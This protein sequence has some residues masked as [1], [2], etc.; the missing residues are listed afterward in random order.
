MPDGRIL[1]RDFAMTPRQ[2]LYMESRQS[3]ARHLAEGFTIIEQAWPAV[4]GMRNKSSG[5]D[6]ASKDQLDG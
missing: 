3:W 1:T 6:V 2:V 5:F 4:C